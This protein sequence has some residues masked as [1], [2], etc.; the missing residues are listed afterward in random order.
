MKLLTIIFILF[1]CCAYC[2]Q[3]PAPHFINMGTEQGLP[4]PEVYCVFEDSKGYMW[5]G[6]DNGV[7]RFDGYEFRNYGTKDGLDG[8]VVFNIF[9]DEFGRIWLGSMTKNVFIFDNGS[10]KPYKFNHVLQEYQSRF[11][12]LGMVYS[13]EKS[14]V[15]FELRELGILSIDAQGMDSLYT[16]KSLDSSIALD[17][18]HL[19]KLA[20]AQISNTSHPDFIAEQKRNS[21]YGLF[22]FSIVSE[23]E[24]F[25]KTLP[26]L[27]SYNSN[28]FYKKRK[29]NE[30]LLFRPNQLWSFVNNDLKYTMAFPFPG[31]IS[32]DSED[33]LWM[34]LLNGK[35][36]RL[37]DSFE[38]IN[39]SNFL[40][41]LDGMSISKTLIDSRGSLWVTTLEN[42]IYYSSNPDMLSYT[43]D[44]G[45]G[46][47]LIRSI[48]VK[49]KDELFINN[50]NHIIRLDVSKHR[51]LEHLK[52]V[53]IDRSSDFYFHKESEKLWVGEYFYQNN[54]L[55]RSEYVN[56]DFIGPVLVKKFYYDFKNDKLFAM[57]F[58]GWYEIDLKSNELFR[59]N[60]KRNLRSNNF[61]LQN[62]NI[63]AS[64]SKRVYAILNDAMNRFW[65]G[66]DNGIF[67]FKDSFFVAPRIEHPSFK[68]R[69]ESIEQMSDSSIVLGTKGWG[70]TIW[71][72]NDII[73]ITEEKGLT[74]NMI[75]TLHI[76]DSNNIWAGT[77]NGLN[78]ISISS[79]TIKVRRYTISNGLPSNEI[80]KITSIENQIWLGTGGGLVKFVERAENLHSP[81]PFIQEVKVNGSNASM[82]T[83]SRFSYGN[84]NWSFKY[85]T[86]NFRQ[87][88][89]TLYRYRI[90]TDDPWE[91][92]YNRKV[93]YAKLSSGIYSFE[94]QSQNEDGYWSA[95]TKH[96][97][98]ILLP[99]WSTWW[100]I[101]L[102]II[103]GIISAYFIYTYSKER[104][105]KAVD[106]RKQM[107]S[108][109]RSALH[110]QMNPHFIFNCLNSI[111]NLI[112]KN[113][114]H[115]AVLYLSKFAELVRQILNI[116]IADKVSLSDN[117]KMITNYL[118][119]E[120]LRFKDKLVYELLVDEKLELNKINIPPL[121]IQPYVENAI[122]HGRNNE[123]SKG[124]LFIK[125][126]KENNYLVVTIKDNGVWTKD[127]K[128]SNSIQKHKSVG[129]SITKK[130][131]ELLDNSN[132]RDIV[133][134]FPANHKKDGTEV[135]VKLKLK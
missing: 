37:Y 50:S 61:N 43:M 29:G 124:E 122:L 10:I 56:G 22:N 102:F 133:Q 70:V 104:N 100:A 121:L 84:N 101:C 24:S 79:D 115:N 72:N 60:I 89:H 20:Q 123:N 59:P 134:V 90:S 126:V 131:L 54:R 66:N 88:D 119:L 85:T 63:W 92:T 112:L 98:E 69:V 18:D 1:H 120:K 5:F 97:F 53:K 111:Q 31:C 103:V 99:W 33:R 93:N 108:L 23:K 16:T 7:S 4:S 71:K 57:S 25:E 75:E 65:I 105:K 125:Y 87:Q 67:Q 47:N 130:R 39:Q 78:K 129:M 32:E 13:K 135:I 14:K 2:Q 27:G 19:P 118:E 6:T 107:S 114:T 83:N 68:T 36:L 49:N 116:S 28:F 106:I 73:S 34:G 62:N 95:S 3:N 113:D 42:G 8:N 110:A 26:N 86:I 94:V 9:E 46:S 52:N 109:K 128:K 82:S 76:D 77:L 74:T 96:Q 30:Y 55:K 44:F 15:Y 48:S 132:N 117:I 81:P 51:I 40:T 80:Y 12:V 35:G 58:S 41:Y 91:L 11:S 17:L 127:N 38:S 21:K 64:N 45:L